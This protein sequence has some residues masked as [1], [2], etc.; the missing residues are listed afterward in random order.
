[1][2]IQYFNEDISFPK[3]KKRIITDWIKKVIIAEG[4]EVG[5][6]SFISCSDEYLL[7]VNKK[8]LEHDYYTDVITFEYVEN[9]IISGDIFISIDRIKANS[10]EFKC[11]FTNEFLRI[12]IH[13][14]LH[15]I[16]YKDKTK[17]DKLLM[18]Q[19]ED[20]Y[21]NLYFSF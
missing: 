3:V 2:S 1:M 19:K 21:L 16:G 15:L 12:L 4:K 8:F 11:D 13:G 6:I 17:S 18:T 7:E 20:F 10:V 5:D 14:V 9:D